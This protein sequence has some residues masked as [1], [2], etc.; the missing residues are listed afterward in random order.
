MIA[1][2]ASTSQVSH[3]AADD[4]AFEDD[5]IAA[6]AEAADIPGSASMA[7][8]SHLTSQGLLMALASVS[9]SHW[10]KGVHVKKI[11]R[12]TILFEKIE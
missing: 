5:P 4:F 2:A 3:V 6:N 7:V 9:M 1:I 10:K 12:C 11:N 8:E